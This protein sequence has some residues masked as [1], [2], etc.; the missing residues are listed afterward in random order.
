M[1]KNTNM[2]SIWDMT[3][4]I[5][6]QKYH[7]HLLLISF[8]VLTIICITTVYNHNEKISHLFKPQQSYCRHKQYKTKR[9]WCE[10]WKTQKQCN[11][12]FCVNMCNVTLLNLLC[13]LRVF[14]FCFVG[15]VSWSIIFCKHWVVSDFKMDKKKPIA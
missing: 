1:I 9:I 3:G 7:Y 13:C 10:I 2:R 5:S 4:N 15:F 12:W 8:D 6:T 14:S 11:S